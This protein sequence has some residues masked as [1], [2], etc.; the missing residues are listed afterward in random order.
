M[1]VEVE[2]RG[3]AGGF[4]ELPGCHHFI[5]GSVFV[6]FGL[7]GLGLVSEVEE[8]W[9]GGSKQT[10]VTKN[11]VIIAALAPMSPVT[12]VGSAYG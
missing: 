3:Y 12:K 4:E 2:H 8:G 10:S 9:G 11:A 6:G 7:E 5:S 1:S